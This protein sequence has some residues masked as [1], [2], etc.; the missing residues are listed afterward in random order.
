M[1]IFG[2][3]RID[4]YI[5]VDQYPVAGQDTFIQEEFE[6]VGGLAINVA[7]TLKNLACKP[8]L[9]SMVGSDDDGDKII[10]YLKEI[11]L[12]LSNVHKLPTVKTGYCYTILD[13]SKERTFF[14]NR[15]QKFISS[16]NDN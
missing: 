9:I 6:M 14:Y 2:G 4:P 7:I 1:L 5:V 12:D 10:S 16:I 11:D 3:I 8:V 13:G 15:I